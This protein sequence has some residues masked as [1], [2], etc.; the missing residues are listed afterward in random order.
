M[1]E[2][3]THRVLETWPDIDRTAS[4]EKISGSYRPRKKQKTDCSA[5]KKSVHDPLADFP[6]ELVAV[7]EQQIVR[8][9]PGGG[10]VGNIA[11]VTA[12][13]RLIYSALIGTGDIPDDWETRINT[14]TVLPDS[15]SFPNCI[16]PSCTSPI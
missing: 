4:V 13:R 12:A 2:A 8:G 9:T 15:D 7:A 10:V 5:S 6:A 11:S 3:R 14:A 16:C 1:E